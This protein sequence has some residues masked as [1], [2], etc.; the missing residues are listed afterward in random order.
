MSR[1]DTGSD[2]G[3]AP[4]AV[5]VARDIIEDMTRYYQILPDTA[6]LI[7]LFEFVQSR[8]VHTAPETPVH[9]TV[10]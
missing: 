2:S 1:P 7:K 6:G 9:P 10:L 8:T 5:P 4:I 3:Y